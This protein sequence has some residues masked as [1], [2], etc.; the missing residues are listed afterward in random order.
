MDGLVQG[1]AD[2]GLEGAAVAEE[3]AEARATLLVDLE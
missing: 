3:A 1:I 2:G